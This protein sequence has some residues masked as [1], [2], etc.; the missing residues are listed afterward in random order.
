MPK[1][2]ETELKKQLK[3]ENLLN[4]YFLFGEEKYLVEYYAE[5][6]CKK[7]VG[8]ADTSFN[9]HRLDGEAVT[10]DEIAQTVDAMPLM[11]NRTCVLVNNLDADHLLAKETEKLNE[12][13][14]DL[15][16]FCV[17]IFCCRS[18][19]VNLKKSAK[20]KKFLAQIE[21]YGASV[22]LNKRGMI[23]LEKQ[24]VSWAKKLG[25]ELSQI[26]ASKIIKLC[27]DDLLTLKNELE[28]L[29][30]FA[31]EGEITEEQI[32]QIITKNL[33]TTVFLLS[34]AVAAG[35][36]KKA[37]RQL[38][39]LFYQKEEP[40]A[41][42][43]VLSSLYTDMYRVRAA[44]ESRKQL[45]DVSCI[46]DYRNKEFRLK[47]AQKDSSALSTQALRRCMNEILMTDIALKS[48]KVDKKILME[49]L[50]AK[51]MMIYKK[52]QQH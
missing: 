47:N 1:I 38:D 42:L 15:P 22:E 27:G 23:A 33:E 21:K 14:S 36:Y 44:I 18:L 52:E 51:L 29:C 28:K 43:A 25:N 24:L 12:L 3:T 41:V 50:L 7:A 13:L 5:E 4:L 30:S 20:W 2:T 39:L 49:E 31:G 26:N 6:L 35:E 19:D 16:D 48:T 9:E 8:E 46:F 45:T 32:D 34:K 40:V 10:I 11:A 17:L 37:Y